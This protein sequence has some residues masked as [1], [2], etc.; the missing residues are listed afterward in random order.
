MPLHARDGG[1][2][3]E[4]TPSGFKVRQSGTWEP[5]QTGYV[6]VGGAWE[7]FYQ[8]SDEV[9]YGF[10]P[11]AVNSWRPSTTWRGSSDMRIGSYGFG[12]HWTLMDFATSTDNRGSG[13][14]L[15]EA[16]AIRP[17]VKG[18]T[19]E[20]A[21]TTGGSST[22]N[23]GTYYISW[24]NGSFGSGAPTNEA[25]YRTTHSLSS[26]GWTYNTT[27]QFSGLGDLA[28]KLDTNSI[29][30]ANN[31]SPSSSGGGEDSDYTNVNGSVT[32]HTLFVRLDYV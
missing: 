11:T 14:T 31:L 9:L 12:D 10:N 27:R 17:V 30:V 20:L 25:T 22:I 13:L 7:T 32:A 3:R 15:G 26:A 18:C 5:V 8:N 6:R 2:W 16:L 1:S 24:N 28:T 19:L 23:A 29:C 21:R 4:I